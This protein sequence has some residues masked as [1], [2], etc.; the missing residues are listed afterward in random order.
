MGRIA[1]P[2][3]Q[4]IYYL[5]NRVEQK[6]GKKQIYIRYYSRKI[7]VRRA[8]GIKVLEK[9]WDQNGQKILGNTQEIRQ[10]NMFL[11]SYKN[12]VDKALLEYK[13]EITPPVIE[14]VLKGEPAELNEVATCKQLIEYCYE[15]NKLRYTSGYCTYRTFENKESCIK[16]F[17]KFLRSIGKRKMTL[18]E[19]D[20]ETIDKFIAYRKETLDN[21][22][23]EG[24]NKSLVPIYK[25][26]EYASDN[27]LIDRTRI[28]LIIKHFLPVKKNA[29]VERSEDK[30]KYLSVEQINEII[31]YHASCKR[32]R[33]KEFLEMWLFSYYACGL[34]ISDIITLEWKHIDFKE[35]CLEKNQFKT[36]NDVAFP[37]NENA[38]AILEK[39]RKKN[40]ERKKKNR[41]VF[42]L[43]ED[44]FDLSKE[45]KLLMK[46]TSLTKTINASLKSVGE[47][48]G[49][50]F[51]IT[52]HVAR[53]SFAVCAINNGMDIK[54]LSRLMGH[55]TTITTEKVYAKIL[56][57]T[58]NK[59]YGEKTQFYEL[60]KKITL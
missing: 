1:P 4:G 8:I 36:G 40:D 23:P 50:P 15:Y 10:N 34:R 24:I 55:T 35:K 30:I 25:A 45:K 41:F 60:T 19:I 42:A 31:K 26:L 29:Y 56:L 58:I 2:V 20:I 44:N 13:G 6:S 11:V 21:T 47:K 59:E 9:D 33:T 48:I 28:A 22:S 38:M 16:V 37:L 57:K 46:K 3:P 12:K 27:G 53:H 14:R 17:S 49:I 54:I 18:A 39:W 32:E 51:D 52:M 43:L 5:H 7:Q